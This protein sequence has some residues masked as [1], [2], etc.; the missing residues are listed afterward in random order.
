MSEATK[1]PAKG[2]K[3]QNKNTEENLLKMGLRG[4]LLLVIRKGFNLAKKSEF[5]GTA[6]EG[7]ESQSINGVWYS[8]IKPEG[9]YFRLEETSE[10]FKNLRALAKECKEDIIALKY[11][12]GVRKLI[13]AVIDIQ[14][15]QAE[16]TLNMSVLKDIKL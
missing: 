15:P 13:D 12:A 3:E 8:R 7:S 4:H 2:K 1:L 11:S 9:A 5:K 10:D 6:F 14:A 16:R